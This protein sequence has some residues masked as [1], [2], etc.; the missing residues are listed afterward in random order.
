MPALLNPILSRAVPQSLLQHGTQSSLRRD[1]NRGTDTNFGG[2][3]ETA[4]PGFAGLTNSAT[5]IIRQLMSGLPS[6]A[7]TQ[8]AN[9]Y[10]GANSGMPGSDFVRNRGFDLYGE[11]AEQY[12]QRG[13][14]DLLALLQGYSGTVAPTT[15]EQIGSDEFQQNFNY[16]VGR[17][18][19]E[20][21]EKA[22]RRYRP[23]INNDNT[24]NPLIGSR[25]GI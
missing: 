5:G 12:K 24:F 20:D 19:I 14:Q 22:A 21:R 4:I 11:K 25:Y 2:A 1:P 6:A 13:F 9:A 16:R 15:G 7:P 8:R 23:P 18:A 3:I 17:D 10:F